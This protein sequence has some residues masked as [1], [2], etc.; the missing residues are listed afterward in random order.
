MIKLTA[1]LFL[2]FLLIFATVICA[3]AAIRDIRGTY[4]GAG[5]L[6]FDEIRQ[7]DFGHY[8]QLTLVTINI[9]EQPNDFGSPIVVGNLTFTINN[10]GTYG[11]IPFTGYL[12]VQGDVF[13]LD[14]GGTSFTGKATLRKNAKA[15]WR[16]LTG[17]WHLSAAVD[18][19]PTHTARFN[20]IKQ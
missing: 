6:A 2:A 18:D 20:L 1:K 16:V 10:L 3:S 13:E 8:Y 5:A 12:K 4:E 14:F 19:L 7:G 11:P 17:Y 9:T 15:K